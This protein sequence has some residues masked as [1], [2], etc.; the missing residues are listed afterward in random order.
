MELVPQ[1]FISWLVI[2]IAALAVIWISTMV[3]LYRLNGYMKKHRKE[4]WS[5]ITSIGSWR[6]GLSNPTRAWPYIFDRQG[7]GDEKLD[8]LKR[9]S[10]AS[11][12]VAFSWVIA[13]LII[14]TIGSYYFSRYVTQYQ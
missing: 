13:F 3:C 7:T 5:Q 9:Y 6:P 4:D 12:L 14:T 11:L 2:S 10:R 8:T 1:L